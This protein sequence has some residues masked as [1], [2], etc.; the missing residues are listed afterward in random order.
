MPAAEQGRCSHRKTPSRGASCSLFL[1]GS[2]VRSLPADVWRSR[3]KASSRRGR[4]QSTSC[5]MNETGRRPVLQGASERVMREVSD[6]NDERPQLG[7][8]RSGRR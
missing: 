8:E 6:A 7:S 3:S 5:P 2:P 4:R 1:C